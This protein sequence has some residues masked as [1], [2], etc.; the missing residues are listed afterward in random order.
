MIVTDGYLGLYLF[1]KWFLNFCLC[2][3]WIFIYTGQ[4]LTSSK[5]RFIII[6]AI[7]VS[8]L[9]VVLVHPH[10]LEDTNPDADD[11]SE[12]GPNNESDYESSKGES[13]YSRHFAFKANVHLAYLG[14]QFSSLCYK[15][16]F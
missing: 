8:L 1:E 16:F 3:V 11:G 6:S 9:L 4:H 15:T 5:M 2:D 12:E 7:L 13:I 10:P 14:W